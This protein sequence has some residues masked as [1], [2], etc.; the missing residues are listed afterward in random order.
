MKRIVGT[1]VAGIA[2]LLAGCGGSIKYV[3]ISQSAPIAVVGFSL[4]K[5]ITERGKSRD[6]GPGLLQK[7]EEYYKNHQLAVNQLWSEFKEQYRDIFLG[8]E[9]VDVDAIVGNES[10]KEL[11]KHVPKKI[12]GKDMAPGS[13]ELIAEGGL[14]YVASE[15]TPNFWTN[16][17]RN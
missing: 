7:P 17:P 15:K 12:M 8:V 16:L 4:D 13:G 5:S 14:N 3:D 11:T 2:I 9:V 1:V 10:Y 6:Q